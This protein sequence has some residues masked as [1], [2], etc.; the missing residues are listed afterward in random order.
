MQQFQHIV[1]F[2][3]EEAVSSAIHEDI[4]KEDVDLGSSTNKGKWKLYNMDKVCPLIKEWKVK[5]FFVGKKS[6]I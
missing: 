2:N 1:Y 6:V 4:N 5:T 3:I